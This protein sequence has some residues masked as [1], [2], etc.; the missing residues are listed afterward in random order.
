MRRSLIQQV[1]YRH[2]QLTPFKPVRTKAVTKWMDGTS[3]ATI[4]N[5]NKQM[6]MKSGKQKTEWVFTLVRHSEE[7]FRSRIAK[8]EPLTHRMGDV[9]S[10][11]SGWCG[12]TQITCPFLSGLSNSDVQRPTAVPR[13]SCHVC[14]NLSWELRFLSL[15]LQVSLT[16][17]EDTTTAYVSDL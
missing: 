9:I 4:V 15:K 5:M 10:F 6:S 14:L 1:F 17:L 12:R 2:K 11:W 7:Y 13:A 3:I 16:K 8:A